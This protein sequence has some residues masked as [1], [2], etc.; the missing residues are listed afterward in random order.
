LDS[1]KIG[2]EKR[3][4]IIAKLGNPNEK[5]PITLCDVKEEY[6]FTAY[7]LG[8]ENNV[9]IRIYC[10]TFSPYLRILD[11]NSGDWEKV[12]DKHPRAKEVNRILTQLSGVAGVRIDSSVKQKLSALNK[13]EEVASQADDTLKA[14]ENIKLENP[15]E[16]ENPTDILIKNLLKNREK[17]YQIRD[18]FERSGK[19]IQ[20]ISSFDKEILEK[21]IPNLKPASATHV[22][23]IKRVSYDNDRYQVS[24]SHNIATGGGNSR[25]LSYR[26]YGNIPYREYTF[27]IS[28]EGIRIFD[29]KMELFSFDQLDGK[30]E[31]REAFLAFYKY[32]REEIKEEKVGENNNQTPEFVAKYNKF[33]EI[34]ELLKA[35]NYEFKKD[36]PFTIV[37]TNTKDNSSLFFELGGNREQLYC[38][39]K[40]NGT[41]GLYL[42]GSSKSFT[43]IPISFSAKADPLLTEVD[44]DFEK[45]LDLFLEHGFERQ[46]S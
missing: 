35:D 12:N 40:Y 43:D 14:E 15:T 9:K 17:F 4:E 16:P 36:S 26:A 18:L 34:L 28:S 2:S 45:V 33:I 13:K 1:I 41:Y 20:E 10:D 38:I 11:N 19:Y 6:G 22:S 24:F 23:K 25:N 3:E 44:I 27:F 21:L 46:T 8:D 30:F 29:S 37:E 32:V 31:Y 42:A 7:Y 39:K 5:S